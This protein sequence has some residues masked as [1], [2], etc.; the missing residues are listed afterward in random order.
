MAWWSGSLPI[1]VAHTEDW[2]WLCVICAIWISS[3]R[4]LVHISS[5]RCS[6]GIL[7]V[8][9]IRLF[10]VIDYSNIGHRVLNN[11]TGRG[12]RSK[13]IEFKINCILVDG[14]LPF[15]VLA[16]VLRHQSGIDTSRDVDSGWGRIT[17]DVNLKRHGCHCLEIIRALQAYPESIFKWR[18][19]V[20]L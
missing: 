19:K 2:I 12:W 8:Q 3:H 16:V 4:L 20:H 18:M 5:I 7:G 17:L 6:L 11:W 10:Q 9:C 14:R 15:L 13:I 1:Q